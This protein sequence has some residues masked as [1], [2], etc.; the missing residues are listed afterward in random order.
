M[1]VIT[2][3]MDDLSYDTQWS[4][5]DRIYRINTKADHL[6]GKYNKISQTWVGMSDALKQYF[7]EVEDVTSIH[8]A[9]LDL[10]LSQSASEVIQV[11]SLE[12]DTL[13]WNVLDFAIV[14]GTPKEFVDGQGNLIISES[15]RKKYFPDENPVG[16][17]VF[18]IPRY[19]SEPTE[20]VITGVMKNLPA[21][22]HLRAEVILVKK[23]RPEPLYKKQFGSFAL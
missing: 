11:S 13:I 4:K 1:S 23:Q 18:Q 12:T 3:V 19:G 14:A 20:Y 15:F 10:K 8:Q 22:T 5:G 9:D 17:S 7:P 16:N 6:G 2:V 21:N